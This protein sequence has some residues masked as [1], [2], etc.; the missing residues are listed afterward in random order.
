MIHL[1]IVDDEI[2]SLSLLT[3]YVHRY[4][5]EH[6]EAGESFQ[7]AAFQD[8]EEIIAGFEPKFDII[9]LDVQM[10]HLDG[11]STAKRIRKLDGDVILIFITNLSHY[12]IRG[13]EVEALSY[14]L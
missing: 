6:G 12:A 9:L 5:K 11:F 1:A 14:L 13:Y 2:Q 4:E 3:E 8:G 10:D 7:I